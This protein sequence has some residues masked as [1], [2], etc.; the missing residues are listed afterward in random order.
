MHQHDIGLFRLQ[1]GAQLFQ[2]AHCDV[3]ERLL[4]AHDGQVVLGR[5]L[6]AL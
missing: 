5:Y 4:V 1:N 6:K 3:K 2:N